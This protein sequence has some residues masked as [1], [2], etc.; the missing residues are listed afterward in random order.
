MKVYKVFLLLGIVCSF[1]P[2]VI[3]KFKEYGFVFALIF[4]GIGSILDKRKR[5]NLYFGIFIIVFG[6]VDLVLLGLGLPHI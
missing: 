6:T 4:I 3:D 2:T 5:F 1:L